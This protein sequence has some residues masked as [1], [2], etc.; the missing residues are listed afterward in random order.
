MEKGNL[1]VMDRPP[2]LPRLFLFDLGN[3][4]V[5]L[6]PLAEAFPLDELVSRTGATR[7]HMDAELAATLDEIPSASLVVVHLGYH[8]DALGPVPDGF[9]FLVPRGQG[10]R[11]LGTL[12][13]HSIFEGRAPD[14]RLLLTTMIGGAHDPEAIDLDDAQLVRIVREDLSEVMDILAAPYFV[15]V[16]R[17]PRGIPQ[18]T[19]GHPD[20]LRRIDS[21]L[22][23]HPGLWVAGNSYHG[24]S[25]NA[26]IEEAPQV[27]DRVLTYLTALKGT[28]A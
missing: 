12:W 28:P 1:S 10:P 23:A 11:I 3:V 16:L 13:I 14:G 22:E 5:S 20:R 7:E 24:I 9:G 15:E 19:L 4:L 2:Q 8:R 17:W 25:V 18:Y 27:A 6:R 26:C 21:R